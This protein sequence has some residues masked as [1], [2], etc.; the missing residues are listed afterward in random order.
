MY[1][2]SMPICTA[3]LAS[4]RNPYLSQHRKLTQKCA[5]YSPRARTIFS[6]AQGI[7]IYNVALGTV[8]A[9]QQQDQARGKA[10]S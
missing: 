5:D 1:L 3:Q 2:W 7:V 10:L 8:I 4:I 6:K 9:A